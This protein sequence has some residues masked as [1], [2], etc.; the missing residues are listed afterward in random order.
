MKNHHK[1]KTL[2]MSNSYNVK[3]KNHQKK[4]LRIYRW[5]LNSPPDT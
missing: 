5:T 3:K 2:Q 1:K 4:N